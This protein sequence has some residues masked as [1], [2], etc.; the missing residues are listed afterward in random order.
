MADEQTVEYHGATGGWGS[1]GGI[2]AVFGKEWSSPAAIET[3]ARQNKPK[4]FMCV[5]CSWA[6]PADPHAFEFCENGA[7]A[8]L[9]EL[10]S[11]RCT[12]EFFA[13]HTVTELR[14][15]ADYDLEQQGRLT[16]PLRYEQTTDKYVACGWDE[17]FQAIG[18]ELNSLDPKSVIFYSS[19]RASLETSYLYG[20]FARAF[21]NNNLPDSSNMC[22]E[23]TSVALKKTIGVGVGTVIFEDLA[24]SD[25]MFFFGQNPGSNSPRFLH[26]LEDAA[27]RGV[28]IITFNPVRE[29]GLIEFINPQSLTEMLTHKA[30]R[31]STQYHQVRAG[32]DVAAILGLCKSVFAADDIAK[33][34]GKRV[35]DVSFIKQHTSGFETF[36]AMVRA[37]DWSLIEQESG[38]TREAIEG[39]ARVYVEAERVTAF[40]GMGLTQQVHGFENVGAAGQLDVAPWKYR[41]RGNG[42]LASARTLECTGAADRRNFRET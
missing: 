9:W 13:K 41:A 36:E 6:K 17:A 4:G 40:Y 16:Q 22:H 10:T 8:T 33:A 25:A 20:L 42:R 27:K 39:A 2:A 32:G 31:I 34:T 3:L 1:L 18:A 38:L 28:Q 26:P 30:T 37:L 7:K 12:P 19:G 21:G 35:L 5:S 14:G 23:T 24:K 15:W 29:K 11:R